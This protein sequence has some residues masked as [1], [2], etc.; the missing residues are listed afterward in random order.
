[1]CRKMN[2]LFCF[3]LGCAMLHGQYKESRGDGYFFSYA[4]ANA[5][6]AYEKDLEKGVSL[7]PRQYLNLADSYFKTNKF[8]KA[9]DIYLELFAQDSIMEGYHLNMLLQGLGRT[10]DK[11]RL[12]TFLAD[13][14]LDFSRELQENAE[15][16]MELL[17]SNRSDEDLNYKV[18]NLEANSTQSDF[19][20]AFYG[21]GL[22][23]TSG[24]PLGNGESYEPTGEAYL[25]VFEG[26]IAA[27]GQVAEVDRL[28]VIRDSDYHKATPYFSEDLNSIFYVL[29]NTL[30]GELEFDESGKNALSI[31]MQKIG[32]SF[33]FLWRD[34]STSF[35]YPFY[36]DSTSRLYFSANLKDG[37]G[38]TDIYYVNTS[39]GQIM[40]A[41]INLGPKINTPGNEIAPYIFEGVFYFSSDVFY[42]LGGMDIYKANFKEG[43]FTIPVNL[44]KPINSEA[45]DFGFIIKNHGDGLQGYFS[46]N[47]VGGK[48]KDDVFGFFVDE[49]PGIK[50]FA[51]NGK[52]VR[53]NNMQG[54]SDARIKVYG[55]GGELLQE[56]LSNDR[57]DYSI[58]IPWQSKVRI[59]GAKDRF[60]IFSAIFEGG[61]I[62]E[63]QK[64]NLNIGIALYDDLVEEREGQKVV[65]LKKFFFGNGVSKVSPDIAI[66]LDKVV[67]F[68]ERFPAV[69]LRIESHT[70]SRGGSA[71]NFRLTQARSDAIK[72]YLVNHGVPTSNILYSIG[73]GEDKILNN[74]KNGVYCLEMLHR[75]NRRSLIVVLNDNILFD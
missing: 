39:N 47:R 11:E 15:F 9:T 75:Q 72:D 42:G 37:Y 41:P 28:N 5:I 29:S 26:E 58:E 22:L 50:T 40:S 38:G 59:E 7:S 43:G 33:K 49:K 74:C 68:V 31:G 65:K 73:Y 57:G 8:E 18:F 10:S 69:Q 60:S 21:T 13:K 24:R 55:P 1:M 3:V 46:S 56:T 6:S 48:G 17:T 45:D 4:Y 52:V 63:V 61:Q 70:D 32:G 35:Y 44:G 16:N 34:L 64:G 66:E 36:D 62:E 12:A 67:D 71:T 20:P 19:S 27:N 30:E 23:L 2:I 25:D 51:L 54:V 14:K 53:L